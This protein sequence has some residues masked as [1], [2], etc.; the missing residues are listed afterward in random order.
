MSIDIYLTPLKVARYDIDQMIGAFERVEMR[1]LNLI[2]I[3]NKII[4]IAEE[5]RLIVDEN[6][7]K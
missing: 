1:Y 6:K 2:S 7:L 4:D 3:Q 5:L